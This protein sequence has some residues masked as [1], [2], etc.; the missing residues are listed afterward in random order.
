VNGALGFLTIVGRRGGLRPSARSLVWF[1]PVGA[2][3]GAAVGLAGWGARELWP[4]VVAAA[5]MVAADAVATGL[6]HLDGLADAGDGLVAPMAP[7][8]RL[9]AMAD[10]GVGAFG[11]ATVGV[12]LA[13]RTAAL[14]ALV[15]LAPGWRL[16]VVLAGWW[17]ASRAVMALALLTLPP[18]RSGGMTALF[19]CTVTERRSRVTGVVLVALP[20]TVVACYA[21]REWAGLSGLM[22][23]VAGSAAVL[24]LARH[25]IGGI[26]GDVLG[27]AGVVGE[28]VAILAGSARW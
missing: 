25:R 27:A 17:A 10:P 5:S 2:L 3:V 18:A 19:A 28:T 16:P 9:D 20:V 7:A 21:G 4:A 22:G 12:V 6:L 8:Q 23:V 14:V 11:V 26:T 1:G 13:V 24:V 15:P